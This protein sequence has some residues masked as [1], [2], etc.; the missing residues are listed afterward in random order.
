MLYFKVSNDPTLAAKRKP[1]IFQKETNVKHIPTTFLLKIIGF[2]FYL[3]SSFVK[4]NIRGW[5]LCRSSTA[6]VFK[7][8]RGKP[9]GTS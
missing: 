5:H 3:E 4:L 7:K 8:Q 1:K 6:T 2:L 9:M